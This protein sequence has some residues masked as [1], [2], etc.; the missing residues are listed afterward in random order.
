MNIKVSF[1]IYLNQFFV[2]GVPYRSCKFHIFIYVSL[3]RYLLFIYISYIFRNLLLFPFS[4]SLSNKVEFQAVWSV[5]HRAFS[6]YVDSVEATE[7]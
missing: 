4:Q 2:T 6:L 3:F 1:C 5:N 7:F